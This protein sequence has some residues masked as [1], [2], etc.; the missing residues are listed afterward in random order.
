MMISQISIDSEQ[1]EYGDVLQFVSFDD[2]YNNL[3]FK[4]QHARYCVEL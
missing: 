3:S 1:A 2:S 4:V